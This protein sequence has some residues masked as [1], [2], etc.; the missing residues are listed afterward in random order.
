M[1]NHCTAF[2][3]RY[4]IFFYFSSLK[5][6]IIVFIPISYNSNFTTDNTCQAI[7]LLERYFV[8]LKRNALSTHEIQ[9]FP[10][11]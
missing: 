1:V 3:D 4:T 6:K 10:L 2:D 5:N 9:I 8:P 11:F 7:A